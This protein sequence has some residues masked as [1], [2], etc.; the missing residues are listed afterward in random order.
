MI[1]LFAVMKCVVNDFL[2][3]G[4]EKLFMMYVWLGH[5]YDIALM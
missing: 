2:A 1:L 4:L 3:I 5:R